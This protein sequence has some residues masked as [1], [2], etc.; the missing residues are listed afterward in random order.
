MADLLCGKGRK[1]HSA[2]ERCRNSPISYGAIENTARKFRSAACAPKG[3]S[4]LKQPNLHLIFSGLKTIGVIQR[5]RRNGCFLENG[6]AS[7]GSETSS[8]RQN[9]HTSG[10]KKVSLALKAAAV[11]LWWWVAPLFFP[12]KM[13]TQETQASGAITSRPSPP[14]N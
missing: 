13:T 3:R 14:S 1:S 7:A 10:R 11:F 12:T 6:A 4:T 5:C 9:K 8:S 2:N